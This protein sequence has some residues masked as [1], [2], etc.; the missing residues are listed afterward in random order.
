MPYWGLIKC[1]CSI[2]NPS[3]LLLSLFFAFIQIADSLFTNGLQCEMKNCWRFQ[4]GPPQAHG[5]L[6]PVAPKSESSREKNLFSTSLLYSWSKSQSI[7]RVQRC[8]CHDC[9]DAT[10]SC[11][12][13]RPNQN[14]GLSLSDDMHI[15][16][17]HKND[18]LLNF[19]PG[20]KYTK[21]PTCKRSGGF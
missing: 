6:P 12:S 1:V 18:M 14:I 5:D 11:Q 10:D 9:F 20:A 7:N 19:P 2:S 17:S 16:T 8:W 13:D 15:K 4:L 3:L 21:A